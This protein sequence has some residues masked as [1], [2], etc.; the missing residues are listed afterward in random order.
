MFSGVR[1]SLA[2]RKNGQLLSL[3]E[4]AKYDIFLTLDQGIA[5]RQNLG[6]RDIAVVILRAKSS[7]VADLEP[8]IGLF[9]RMRQD[10]K[11]GSVFFV[12]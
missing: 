7:R 2:E 8:Q 4:A 6:G 12:G 1:L 9:L 10:A 11:K 5:Y 3:A